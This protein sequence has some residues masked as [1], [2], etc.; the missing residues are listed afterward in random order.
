MQ[1]THFGMRVRPPRP[2]EPAAFR[3]YFPV[4]ALNLATSSAGT[5][6]R[7]FTSMPCALAPLPDL[8]EVQPAHRRPASSPGRPPATAACPPG[9]AHVARQRASQL[10]GMPGAQIDLVLRAVQPEADGA[11]C[12]TAIKVI[13]QLDLYLLSHNCLFLSRAWRISRANPMGS[14]AAGRP[15]PPVPGRPLGSHHVTN[16][17]AAA[18]SARSG[19]VRAT[20]RPSRHRPHMASGAGPRK[21]GCHTERADRLASARK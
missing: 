12:L 5:R 3:T 11:V 6:P 21:P 10:P 8:S 20:R 16:Q 14:A 15:C 13:D 19:Y 9:A 2:G 7:S 4:A 18:K 1:R 17:C